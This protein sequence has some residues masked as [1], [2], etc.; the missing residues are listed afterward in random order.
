MDAGVTKLLLP[1]DGVYS[2]NATQALC[3]CASRSAFV[4]LT[5]RFMPSRRGMEVGSAFSDFKD[6][7]AAFEKLKK[8]QYHPLRV[9]NSHSAAYYSKK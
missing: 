4:S 5:C 8:E 2:H 9:Y 3:N 7:E 1:P 6:V